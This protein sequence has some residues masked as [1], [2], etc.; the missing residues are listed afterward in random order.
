MK[1]TIN[2]KAVNWY[3]KELNLSEGGSV[4]FFVRYGGSSSIQPGFS[5][6]VSTDSPTNAGSKTIEGGITFFI[7]EEDLWY[8]HDHDLIITY[9][10]KA[11]EPVFNYE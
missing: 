7:E 6:G 5:L 10:E 11:E 8:F 4:R 3:K 2:E 9:N 1:I